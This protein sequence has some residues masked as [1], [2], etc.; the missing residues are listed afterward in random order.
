MILVGDASNKSTPE[1][2][3]NKYNVK[4]AIKILVIKPPIT[5]SQVFAGL[6]LSANM[7]FPYFFPEK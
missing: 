5:P 3:L 2:S 7:C 4:K 6:T 1:N